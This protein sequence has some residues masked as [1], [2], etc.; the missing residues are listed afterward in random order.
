MKIKVI[1]FLLVLFIFS[2]VKETNANN[3]N[4][5]K[6]SNDT[7][8]FTSLLTKV[9]TKIRKSNVKNRKYFS[10]KSFS[11]FDFQQMQPIEGDIDKEDYYKVYYSETNISKITRVNTHNYFL[12]YSLF[13]FDDNEFT[14]LVCYLGDYDD[15]RSIG[16]TNDIVIYDKKQRRSVCVTF[17]RLFLSNAC[18]SK[19]DIDFRDIV[20]FDNINSNDIISIFSLDKNLK[21]VT[22]INFDNN[23]VI[24]F[25]EMFTN[26]DLMMVQEKMVVYNMKECDNRNTNLNEIS[27]NK[28]CIL[29]C[30][31]YTCEE[32]LVV[33]VTPSQKKEAPVWITHDRS[34][35]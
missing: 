31:G 9:I 30:C 19:E 4:T 23:K 3:G 33:T 17:D 14:Y 10:V 7:I 28:L 25:S 5:G 34:Y 2:G 22:R 12:N 20:F 21:A 16:F 24:S 35:Y 8:K 29:L 27:Y 13:L 26:K 11:G 15:E 32:E 6:H 18:I 1:F